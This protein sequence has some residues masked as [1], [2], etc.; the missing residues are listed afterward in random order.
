MPRIVTEP[1]AAENVQCS[2]RVLRLWVYYSSIIFL[3]GAEAT[4]LSA[5]ALGWRLEP[6]EAAESLDKEHTREKVPAGTEFRQ[7]PSDD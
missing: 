6:I 1:T 2:I 5:R 4:Q 3:Y 7:V